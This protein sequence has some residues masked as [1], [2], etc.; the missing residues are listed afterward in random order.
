MPKIR[1]AV[2]GCCHGELNQILKRVSEL[3]KQKAL[4]LLLI[5]GDFQSIRNEN[6]LVSLSVPSKYQR[7]GD[8]HHYYDD[9]E[10]KPPCMTVFIGGNHESMRHL[11]LLP[12]G[13]FVAPN[14]YYMGYSNVIWYRGARIAGLS[15]I[16]KRWDYERQRPS[17]KELENSNQWSR[18]VKELYHIRSDDVKPLLQLQ[19]PVDVVMSHDWPNG[20]AYHGDLQWLVRTKPFFKK[21]LQSRQL[22]SPISWDLLRQLKPNWWLSAHLH[23][24]YEALVKHG[25][26][27]KDELELDL[28]EDEEIPQ[29]THFL[30]LDKCLPRRK[31]LEVI[32]VDVDESHESWHN[33]NT[34]F[35]DPEFISHLP[36]AKDESDIT[37]Y[38]LPPYTRGIQR[39]EA[40]QTSLFVQKFL[41]V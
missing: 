24:R 32:E 38:T 9:D 6:D 21:D 20:V 19:K 10:F 27:N 34:I 37:D 12:H 18:K 4:D 35:M 28:S 22:G 29:E 3:H 16:W 1:V 11:M 2:E 23:V 41:S 26:R 17:W 7:M 31:W 5:L 33:P 14:I 15:G 25:K 8:F 40:M 39:E 36:R 13:G 30:A